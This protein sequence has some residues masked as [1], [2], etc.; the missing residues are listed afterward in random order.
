MNNIPEFLNQSKQ[1]LQ[2]KYTYRQ[3]K[4]T[5]SLRIEEARALLDKLLVDGVSLS[6]MV[7]E[8]RLYI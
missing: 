8:D 2:K 4:E 6:D 1:N 5:K 3:N 7:T